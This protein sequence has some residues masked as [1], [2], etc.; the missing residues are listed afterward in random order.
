MY[1]EREL[2][3]GTTVAVVVR[4]RTK[5]RLAKTCFRGRGVRKSGN[6]LRWQSVE[7]L[8]SEWPVWKYFTK[9]VAK[10]Y[11]LRDFG[12]HSYE[13]NLGEKLGWE[14]TSRLE[15]FA[16]SSLEDFKPNRRSCG[17]RVKLNATHIMAPMTTFL[18]FVYELKEENGQAVAI[19]HSI[20]PGVD[21]GDLDGDVTTRE[22]RVFFD[23]DHPGE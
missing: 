5:E 18:T 19:V 13:F 10:I 15:A 23:F 9:A 17:L 3:N 11:A 6:F 7:E 4:Q 14:S 8:F 21:I 1:L 22:G 20:Y 12:I 2:E 16:P